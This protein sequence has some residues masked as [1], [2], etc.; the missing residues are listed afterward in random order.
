MA[1]QFQ[2]DF[3]QDLNQDVKI[4]QCGTIVFTGDNE[5]NIITVSL[6][7]GQEPAPQTGSVACYVIRSDGKTVPTITGSISGNV[8]SATLT[9][10]CFTRPGPIGVGI[11]VI[12]GTVKTTVLKA[13]YNVETLYTDEVVDPSGEITLSVGDLVQRIDDAVAS[14]PADYSD[15][16]AAIAPNYTDLEFPVTAG[17]WCWYS[18]SLHQATV[19]IP[20][21]ES[22]TAAHWETA[23]LGNALAGDIADLKS[24]IENNLYP[25]VLNFSAARVYSTFADHAHKGNG[26][27]IDSTTCDIDRYYPLTAGTIVHIK[28]SADS[29][30]TWQFQSALTFGTSTLVGTCHSGAVDGYYLVPTGAVCLTITRLK[31]NTSNVVLVQDQNSRVDELF[32]E[33]GGDSNVLGY[34]T[35]VTSANYVSL[36]ADMNDM[37]VNRI[38]RIN[39]CLKSIDN[40]PSGVSSSSG[41]IFCY[42]GSSYTNKSWYVQVLTIASGDMYY[43]S[44]WGGT[45][46]AWKQFVDK[47]YVDS[48]AA[49]STEINKGQNLL[50][51]YFAGTC[52]NKK[53]IS[54]SSGDHVLFYGDS[55]T[56]GSTQNPPW[57]NEFCSKLGVTAYNKAVSGAVYGHSSSEKP[58][59]YWISTQ[60]DNTT[61]EE[62]S[63]AK[64]IFVAAGTNDIGYNIA[65]SETA[66]YVQAAINTIRQNAPTTPIVFITPI[67][68]GQQ[69]SEIN[70]KIPYLSGVITN[71]A[72]KNECN[73]ICGME[74]PIATYSIDGLIDNLTADGLHPNAT[75][76]KVYARAVINAIM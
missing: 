20:A 59:A 56:H 44:C 60:M 53:E 63:N 58:E 65:T 12:D 64:L 24:D 36:L 61:A 54:L 33:F 39:G 35:F 42:S 45:W 70:L 52:V 17:T 66:Q 50:A 51:N 21:S 48:A 28:A 3:Y 68:R 34:D 69:T 14:I 25:E 67:R 16:L 23:P 37:P 5:S 30:Y 76:S 55:I 2:K 43:R 9:E 19:D 41:T 62:W 10:A 47:D 71:I 29:D 38:Y 15:L 72:L 18:G 57:V 1:A 22:W 31:T 75:G 49:S 6:F 7:N 13:V 26:Q 32:N 74:F 73:V 27:S 8:V 4:R 40:I 11:Q 46:T